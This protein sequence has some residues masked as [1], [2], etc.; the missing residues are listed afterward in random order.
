LLDGKKSLLHANLTDAAAGRALRWLAALFGAAA[1]ANVANGARWDLDRYS[2]AVDGT[3]EFELQFISE[4]RAG[5]LEPG[6]RDEA[7]FDV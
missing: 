5:T 1:A 4:V 7:T 6:Q 2:I 3:L